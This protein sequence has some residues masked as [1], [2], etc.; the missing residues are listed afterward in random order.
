VDNQLLAITRCLYVVQYSKPA[1][2]NLAFTRLRK[3]AHLISTI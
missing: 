1:I 2:N 3:K